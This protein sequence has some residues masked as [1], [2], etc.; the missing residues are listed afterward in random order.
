MWLKY[1]ITV[2]VSGIFKNVLNFY[3]ERERG[4]GKAGGRESESQALSRLS[5]QSQNVGLKLTNC[6][7]MT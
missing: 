1:I 6:E 4:R 3:L 2:I 5:V 7:I